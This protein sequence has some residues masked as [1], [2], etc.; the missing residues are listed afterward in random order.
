[1]KKLITLLALAGLLIF[2]TSTFAQDENA[3]QGGTTTEL[4]GSTS[5]DGNT[6]PQA[7]QNDVNKGKESSQPNQAPQNSNNKGGEK[8][9]GSMWTTILFWVLLIAVIYFFMIRPASKRNKEARKFRES[10]KKGSKVITAG[11]IYGII[12]EIN[13]TYALL[14]IANGVR[15]KIDLNSIV[16]YTEAEATNMDKDSK[17]DS[18]TMEKTKK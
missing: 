12:D 10:L 14:E 18:N 8:S 4:N 9:G 11:G 6:K 1:M 7:V 2:S 15:I 17:K 3:S 5:D 16:S 13:E